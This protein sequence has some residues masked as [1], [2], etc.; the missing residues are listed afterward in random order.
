MLPQILQKGQRSVKIYN[1]TLPTQSHT[2]TVSCGSFIYVQL[3]KSFWDI[4]HKNNRFDSGI[5]FIYVALAACISQN[6]SL[7]SKSLIRAC[8]TRLSSFLFRQGVYSVHCFRIKNRHELI[9][10]VA[11]CEQ[12]C[13]SGIINNDHY[14]IYPGFGT[15]N[16]DT[17]QMVLNLL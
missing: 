8:M 1:F 10:G 16:A 3:Q 14:T 6:T 4:F 7:L 17:R 5:I 13:L 15:K 2:L 12:T 9:W 11:V